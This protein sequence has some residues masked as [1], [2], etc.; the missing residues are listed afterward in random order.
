MSKLR[1]AA[2]TLAYNDEGIIAGTLRCLAPY[3]ERH[4]VLISEEP[5]FGEP[6]PPDNTEAIANALGAQV[7]KG[8][9]PLDHHQRNVGVQLCQDVD[10]IITFDSDEMM[11]RDELD[12]FIKFLGETPMPAVAVKPEVYWK[13][14]DFRLRPKPDYT[15]ILAVRPEVAFTYIRNINSPY[16]LWEGD[17]H[18]VSWCAP[19]DI[20][21][22]VIHY[23]HATD[24][25]GHSWYHEKY[26]PWKEGETAKLPTGEFTV[27]KKPLPEELQA[28]LTEG[29][30][31]VTV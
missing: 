19:K 11:T 9:W 20:Y 16:A 10:W 22:K 3:V 6:S 30:P 25:N 7:V 8:T 29:V 21:K 23:A 2:N 15:P 18:H 5:Y 14:T 17:M 26:V 1:L 28:H 24:F 13:T 12:A 31:N 27:I 4:I